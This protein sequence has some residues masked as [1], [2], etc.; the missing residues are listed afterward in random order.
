MDAWLAEAAQ[1][2]D[3]NTVISCLNKADDRI[4]QD[5]YSLPLFQWPALIAFSPKLGN[6]R[7]NVT[8]LGPAYDI[9]EWG[10]RTSNAERIGASAAPCCRSGVIFQIL[11]RSGGIRYV[12][13]SGPRFWAPNLY[14]GP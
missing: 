6:V 9:R 3:Q 12:L 2:E 7:D 13:V 1:S 5:A 14:H 4:S 10:L 8:G 11:R